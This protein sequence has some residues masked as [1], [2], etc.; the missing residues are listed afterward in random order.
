MVNKPETLEACI[1]ELAP[2]YLVDSDPFDVERLAWNIHTAEYG[3]AGEVTQSALAAFDIA[4][5]DLAGQSLGVPIWKLIGGRFHDRVPAYANGW[6]QTER[7]PDA[8]AER[9]RLVTARGYR[10]LKLDPFGAAHAELPPGEWTR[11]ESIVAAVRNAV[12]PDGQVCVE[13]HGRFAPARGAGVAAMLE[14]YD[15]DWIEEPVPPDDDDALARVRAATR[16]PIATGER[17]HTIAEIRPI[18]ERGLA[19][20]IQIDLTH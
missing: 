1:H 4:C 18:V 3:R 16:I 12:G 2:R 7:Q 11:V 19:D 20:V 5:R 14:P 8:I 10:A 15:P 13:M 17:A 9:A 6:Y